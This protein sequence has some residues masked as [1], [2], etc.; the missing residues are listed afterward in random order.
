MSIAAQAWKAVAD[1]GAVF[2]SRANLH[3]SFYEMNVRLNHPVE[4][5]T[6]LPNFWDI[7]IGGRRPQLYAMMK[8]YMSM[9]NKSA[10]LNKHDAYVGYLGPTVYQLFILVLFRCS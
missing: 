1:F 3:S 2:D 6:M 7:T 10:Y 5:Q 8:L 9:E 4:G